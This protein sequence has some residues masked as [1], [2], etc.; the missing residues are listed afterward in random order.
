MIQP[1]D[2]RVGWK[3][4]ATIATLAIFAGLT[5]AGCGVPGLSSDDSAQTIA[6]IDIS[7]STIR[8][9]RR[10]VDCESEIAFSS[11]R[12]PNILCWL[13]NSLDPSTVKSQA[14]SVLLADGRTYSEPDWPVD[15]FNLQ[16]TADYEARS[17][18]AASVADREEVQDKMASDA[19]TQIV[20]EIKKSA[21]SQ[22]KGGSDL[23]ATMLVIGRRVNTLDGPVAVKMFTDG[24]ANVA[25]LKSLLHGKTSPAA[26]ERRIDKILDRLEHNN[27]L[28]NLTNSKGEPVTF[29]FTG[30]G[31]RARDRNAPAFLQD[32]WTSYVERSGGRVEQ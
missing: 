32:F 29:E 22:G 1:A 26:A 8:D 18:A 11:P 31:Y 27:E 12:V 19:T 3:L 6:V 28:P 21:Q 16:A 4:R 13:S 9:R 7:G 10:T 23:S 5:H 25:E 14:V 2:R 17:K 15:A 24:G 30:L 20:S